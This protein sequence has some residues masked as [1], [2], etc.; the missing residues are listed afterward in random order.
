MCV[1]GGGGGGGVRLKDFNLSLF[2]F[3]EFRLFRLTYCENCIN[4]WQ[5]LDKFLLWQ[6]TIQCLQCFNSAVLL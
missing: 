3:C 5:F 4:M 1:V 6:G 2:L